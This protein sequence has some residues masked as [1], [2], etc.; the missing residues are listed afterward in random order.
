VRAGRSTSGRTCQNCAYS[1]GWV[2]NDIWQDD[3]GQ[4]KVE[5][6]AQNSDLALPTILR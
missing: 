3:D 1:L 2:G 4:L 5:E 6:K